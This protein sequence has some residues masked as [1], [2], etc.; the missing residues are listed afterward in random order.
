MTYSIVNDIL[1]GP[2]I[3]YHRT[4]KSSGK[5]KPKFLVIHY[6]A[7]SSFRNDVAT[8]SSS[9]VQASCQL[10]IGQ[11]GEIAQIGKL[12]DCLWHAGQ[13]SW[14]G[15]NG[16]NR[17]SIGIEVT[18]PGPVD[19]IEDYGNM[20][21]IKYWWGKTARVDKS[22]L[23]YAPPT[24]GGPPRWWVQFTEAQI[25]KLIEVGSLL[26]A[27]YN[28]QEAVGHDQIAP[29]RKIDPG[30]CCPKSVFDIL[31]GRN[32]SDEFEPNSPALNHGIV[33]GTNGEGLNF[34][35]SPNGTITGKLPETT[36]VEILSQNGVWLQVRTPAGYVGWVHG[37][38]VTI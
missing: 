20:A 34:R 7:G 8:L 37:K 31:N 3:E 28:L 29:T 25:Q 38:Y 24:N 18:C 35:D 30:P 17:Y 11:D 19:V 9:N 32:V 22:T 4:T 26:M 13:S 23:V 27:H 33:F 15:Y 6:T 12:T 1:Q 14:R 10:V 36:P 5:I 21:L 2:D 16:L